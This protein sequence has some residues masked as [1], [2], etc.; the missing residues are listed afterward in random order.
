MSGS[1]ETLFL[2]CLAW[3]VKAG[4]LKKDIAD[5]VPAWVMGGFLTQLVLQQ[6]PISNQLICR[7]SVQSVQ[8]YG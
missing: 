2:T 3:S 4:D 1:A 6:I 5:P 7:E 8:L